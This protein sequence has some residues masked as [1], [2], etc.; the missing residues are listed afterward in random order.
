MAS[1]LCEELEADRSFA[2]PISRFTEVDNS[3]LL[4][5]PPQPYSEAPSS[6]A[7]EPLDC[8]RVS[9]VPRV[10]G[11]DIA[12]DDARDDV[13]SPD[14]S[15]KST[16]TSASPETLPSSSKLYDEPSI[17]C[18]NCLSCSSACQQ[19]VSHLSVRHH[20]PL[21]NRVSLPLLSDETTRRLR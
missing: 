11:L 10:M 2:Q 19:R 6:M 12:A 18:E 16:S 15:V 13:F 1:M 8:G 9:I 4:E 20:C 21:S 3:E 17:S 5:P 14:A 7:I